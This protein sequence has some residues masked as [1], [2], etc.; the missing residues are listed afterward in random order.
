MSTSGQPSVTESP[1][2]TGKATAHEIK[3][4]HHVTTFAIAWSRKNQVEII[5]PLVF[6]PTMSPTACTKIDWEMYGLPMAS[7]KN[8]GC[9]V[10]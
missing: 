3:D 6:P 10:L 5:G 4:K 8:R 9:C 7:Q 2:R 1:T